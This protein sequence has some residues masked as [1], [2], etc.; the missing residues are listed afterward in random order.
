MV[1]VSSLQILHKS[2]VVIYNLFNNQLKKKIAHIYII[3]LKLAH[4]LFLMFRFHMV[5]ESLTIFWAHVYAKNMNQDHIRQELSIIFGYGIYG[6]ICEQ[7]CPL[8]HYILVRL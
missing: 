6:L 7:L 3:Y 5:K 2:K 4:Q 8:P 1:A